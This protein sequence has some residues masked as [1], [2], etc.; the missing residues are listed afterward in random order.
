MV[1]RTVKCIPNI[2]ISINIS[3]FSKEKLPKERGGEGEEEGERE[4]ERK[5][6]EVFSNI[7]RYIFPLS[8][9]LNFTLI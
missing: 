7:Y 5:V 9:Y 1:L 8:P 4:R 2:F 3:F 6:R